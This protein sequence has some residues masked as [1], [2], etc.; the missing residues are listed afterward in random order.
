MANDIEEYS[1]VV[2]G[3]WLGVGAEEAELL[4][5]EEGG[6]D[7]V[8]RR[9]NSLHPQREDEGGDR[10]TYIAR[11]YAPAD[12]ASA[13]YRSERLFYTRENA[14]FLDR[15]RQAIEE[16]RPGLATVEEG[17][18]GKVG[19]RGSVYE[20]ERALLLGPLVYEAAT[21]ANTSGVFK[22]YHKG[23]GGHGRDALGRILKPMLLERPLLWPGE[24]AEI[25]NEDA[26][27]F[28]SA[29]PAELCYLDPPYNQHQYGSNYHI[30]NTIVRWDRP[31]VDE[32]RRD[33]GSFRSKAGIPPS[34]TRSRSAFC[35]R[36]LA[37]AA[38]RELAA[39]VDAR[40]IVLSYNTE[41]FVDPAEM[42][43]ILSDRAEV[44]LRSVDYV[45]YRGGRQSVSRKNGTRE[46]LFIARR[47]EG[48]GKAR[49]DRAGG[50]LEE[51]RAE[52]R[53]SSALARPYDP[54]T[55]APLADSR[56][57][58]R[59]ALPGRRVSLDSYLR[60]VFEPEARSACSSLPASVKAELASALEALALPDNAAACE[61]AAEL[62]EEGGRDIRLQSLALHW[63]R[64]IAHRKYAGRYRELSR[65]LSA[66]V[67]SDEKGLAKLAAG[68]VRLDGLFEARSGEP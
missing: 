37:P 23:F 30:L 12:T 6:L 44:E 3:C 51:F 1:A 52:A 45:K 20:K 65:R 16:L 7:S 36:R 40:T 25:G 55:L 56:G 14:L 29:R 49:A 9:L 32:A 31:P 15:S 59:F 24:G 34:W 47:K 27:S 62:I 50:T 39:R 63:L 5:P 11:H 53:L 38:F 54:A 43:E 13:D 17:H 60:L 48:R 2:N 19:D 28:C 66:T 61:K 4:F 68:L 57:R 41:G 64:T 26:A 46:I 58:I 21:H 10:A 18:G 22:A 8:L 35:S 42:T 33:D 67:A